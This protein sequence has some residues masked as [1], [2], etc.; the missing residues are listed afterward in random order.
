[1]GVTVVD[2][3]VPLRDG[4]EGVEVRLRGDPPRYLGHECHA[5]DL[6]IPSHTGT[7]FETSAH[8]FRDGIR[9]LEVPPER[10]VLQGVCLSVLRAE[11]RIGAAELEAAR[12]PRLPPGSA[13]LIRTLPDGSPP[14]RSGEHPFFTADAA[15]WMAESQVALMGS[16]TPLYDTGFEEPTGFFVELFKAR[17]AIIANVANLHLLPERGFTLVALPLAVVGTCTVPCRAV[18]L[19]G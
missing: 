18:A 9:T 4:A 6:R 12:G 13:L 11:R 7:Y 17:I 14:P 2:L 3:S 8:L 16:D 15:R 1:M 5:Y 19:V 10:L